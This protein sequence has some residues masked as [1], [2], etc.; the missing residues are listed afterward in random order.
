MVYNVDI[1]ANQKVIKNIKIDRQSDNSAATVAFVK[2]LIPHTVNNVYRQYFEEF[3]NFKNASQYS[4]TTRSSGVVINGLNPNIG[5]PLG[6]LSDLKDDGLG[7]VNYV[8]TFTSP[9]YITEYTLCIVFYLW[10]NGSFSLTKKNSDNDNIFL[11]LNYNK[12]NKKVGLTV[13]RTT[14]SFTIPNDFN[15]KKNCYMA[16][17][18]I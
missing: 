10:L 17:R 14:Q 3:Y 15:G 9:N 11:K 2:E 4:L 18:K 7:V 1:N 13:G 8:I 16:G 5:I 6:H 12:R